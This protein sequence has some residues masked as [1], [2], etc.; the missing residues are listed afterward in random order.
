MKTTQFDHIVFQLIHRVHPF[1]I[2][3]NWDI[4]HREQK[5]V[6]MLAYKAKTS[7]SND[8]IS[9]MFGERHSVQS[10]L[11]FLRYAPDIQVKIDELV[12]LMNHA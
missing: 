8:E 10:A 3:D 6:L 1:R 2:G 7:L 12:K 11:R 5:M 9:S 4:H